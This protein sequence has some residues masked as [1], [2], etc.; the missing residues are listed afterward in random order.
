M[1]NNISMKE[2]IVGKGSIFGK[3]V[4]ANKDFK[5]GEVVIQYNVKLLSED[6]YKNLPNEE[7]YFV[8]TH[9]GVKYL[10]GIPERYV[11]HSLNP[12]TFSDIKNKC[13]VATRDIKTGEQIT[14]NAIKDDI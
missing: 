4:Y 13:D 10:Y 9:W 14:T 12:N 6:E 2:I 5:R 7:K 8:H 3:G 1:E 11:N